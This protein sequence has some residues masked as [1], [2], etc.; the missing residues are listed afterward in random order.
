[1]ALA[2][3]GY[4]AWFGVLGLSMRRSLIVGIGYIVAFEGLLANFETVARRLTVMYYFRVLVLRWLDAPLGKE[5]SI[6]L[7]TAPSAGDCVLT[8]L[9]ASAVFVLIGALT[10]T[11]REFRMKTPEGT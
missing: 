3:V 8:L 4:C 5:W 10:M 1:L 7:T 11:R 6:D 2:Q 9:G